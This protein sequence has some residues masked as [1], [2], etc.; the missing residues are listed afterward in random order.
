MICEKMMADDPTLSLEK[1]V[2][3]A[4]YAKNCEPN[5]L[6]F[7]AF[8]VNFGKNPVIP[9]I[10]HSTPSSLEPCSKSEAVR[11][12]LARIDKVRL[13]FRKADSNSRL[14]KAVKMKM[15]P[16]VELSYLPGAEVY[17]K[18]D[19]RNEWSSPVIVLGKDEKMILLKNT[20]FL[21]RVS[22]GRV[23]PVHPPIFHDKTD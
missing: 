15:N 22:T 2:A 17:F 1:A 7:S 3:L 6:G 14:K 5:Y 20:N 4:C 9:G 19:G 18:E 12:I 8:Q 11:Q 13:E 23:M 21:H 16:L 10:L